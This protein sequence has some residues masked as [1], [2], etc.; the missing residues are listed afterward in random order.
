MVFLIPSL[1]VFELEVLLR[2]RH[3]G[4]NLLG[5]MIRAAAVNVLGNPAPQFQWN[6]SK[7]GIQAAFKIKSFLNAQIGI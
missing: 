2:M 7:L 6:E 3:Q 4:C 1:I 5:L